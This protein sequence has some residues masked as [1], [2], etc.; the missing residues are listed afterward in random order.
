M[1]GAGAANFGS[2]FSS[3]STTHCLK[4]TGTIKQHVPLPDPESAQKMNQIGTEIRNIVPQHCAIYLQ[5]VSHAIVKVF[6]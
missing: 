3:G 6:T 1:P 4:L 5:K 2:G